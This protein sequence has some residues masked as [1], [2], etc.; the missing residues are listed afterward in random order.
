[1]SIQNGEGAFFA[2]ADRIARLGTLHNHRRLYPSRA[3]SVPFGVLNCPKMAAIQALVCRLEQLISAGSYF[4]V[5]E[6]VD[7]AGIELAAG[8]DTT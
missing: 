5:S 6:M 4:E 1:M 2:V 3:I 7:A 8:I